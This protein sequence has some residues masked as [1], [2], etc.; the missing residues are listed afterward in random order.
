VERRARRRG[1]LKR[2]FRF[3]RC[4]RPLVLNSLDSV[5]GEV[6][7][8]SP[9][10]QFLFLL[11]F[12]AVIWGRPLV[13][14]FVLALH[15]DEY[16]HILLILPVSIALIVLE[17]KSL[18]F[19]PVQSPLA[20][21]ALLVLAILIGCFN[22]WV[23]PH[24]SPGVPLSLSM[25]AVVI[26]WLGSFV[27]CFG[28]QVSLRLLFPLGF[29]FCLLPL[30]GFALDRIVT[31]LQ[32]ESAYATRLLFS[33][34][35][36]PVMQNGMF[37]SIP[38]VT[39]EVAREC[40]SIRSSLMLLVT[41]MVLAHLFL[42]SFWRKT[43]VVLVAIPL[44]V[45]KNAVRIFTLS[46]LGVHVDPGFLHGSLHEKGGIVF[47]ILALLIVLLLLWVLGRGENKTSHHA[48]LIL[49]KP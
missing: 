38:G 4:W 8:L 49:D 47:F 42:H 9:S 43:V 20:G 3:P 24:F 2:S 25:L 30:P 16:T 44:S 22:L 12:S 17:W 13:T 15:N 6:K 35:G 46:M 37:I 11:A 27:F 18:G 14:T 33:A 41:S 21:A 5:K 31:L 29:L 34:T 10:L 7:K 32:R 1:R 19:S 26:W 23:A 45:A 28:T 40:S 48:A 36:V 39:V